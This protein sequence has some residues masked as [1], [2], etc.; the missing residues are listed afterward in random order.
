MKKSEEGISYFEEDDIVELDVYTKQLSKEIGNLKRIVNIEKEKTEGLID[1]YKIVYEDKTY[2]TVQIKNGS[3]EL[4]SISVNDNLELV[5]KN[6]KN[7]DVSIDND[8]NLI[9]DF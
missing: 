2:K 5:V 9:I 1:Y 7:I 4:L 3:T 6:S 8:F